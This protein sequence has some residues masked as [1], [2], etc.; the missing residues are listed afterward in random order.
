[1][2]AEDIDI[3]WR[4]REAGYRLAY[5]PAARVRHAGSAS[6]VQAFGDERSAR[7]IR[8]VYSWMARRRGI[9]RAR[10]FALV[11]TAGSALRWLLALP[12]R[13]L[14]F[15]GAGDRVSLFRSYVKLHAQGFAPRRRLLAGDAEEQPDSSTTGP[16]E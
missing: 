16:T 5:E 7:H 15:R 9:G 12:G 10:A 3:A 11:N 1:M 13:A 14:G 4:L 8:A 2:Y 6:A